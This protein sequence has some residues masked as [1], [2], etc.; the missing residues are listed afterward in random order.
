MKPKNIF[1]RISYQN[2]QFSFSVGYSQKEFCQNYI[3]N[4]FFLFQSILSISSVLLCSFYSIIEAIGQLSFF[5][6]A[7]ADELLEASYH[8][9]WN[10]DHSVEFSTVPL[11][12]KV[13]MCICVYIYVWIH[14]LVYTPTYGVHTHIYKYKPK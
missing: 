13:N 14:V 9:I 3:C 12:E 7:S 8:N 1:Y 2:R 11:R 6:P 5:I 4:C 10:F